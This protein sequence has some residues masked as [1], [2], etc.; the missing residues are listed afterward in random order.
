[1]VLVLVPL[2]LLLIACVADLRT[3]EVP[4]WIALLICVWGVVAASCGFHPFGW[5]GLCLGALLGFAVSAPLF[6]FGGFGGAD[7]KL[8][9]AV[10][11]VLGPIPLLFVLFWM[12][13]AGAV[14]ALAAVARGQRDFAY[15]PAIA[16]GFV[17]YLIYPGGLWQQMFLS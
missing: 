8:I 13:L 12:A 5:W 9:A 14:L 11:A 7:V 3:R 15:V 10:G 6:Y 1:M 4:D 16:T 17:A 2:L